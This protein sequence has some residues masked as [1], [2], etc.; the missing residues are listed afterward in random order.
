VPE[1]PLPLFN[2]ASAFYFTGKNQDALADINKSIAIYAK[3]APAFSQRGLIYEKLGDKD[4][5][6]ADFR[7][8]IALEPNFK[9]AAD[10]LIRLGQRPRR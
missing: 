3:S 10:G 7:R 5:A 9:E 4:K 8:A 2:R 6:I 1:H